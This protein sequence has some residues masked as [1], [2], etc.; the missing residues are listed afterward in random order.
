MEEPST[1][2]LSADQRAL[3]AAAD[4]AAA[5]YGVC[6]PDRVIRGESTGTESL[7][8]AHP[9]WLSFTVRAGSDR[10]V[11]WLRRALVQIFGL[12]A[13]AWNPK[14]RGWRGYVSSVGLGALGLLAFGGER[15][16]NT[17]HVQLYG[18]GCG[19]VRDWSAVRV[20]GE[21]CDAI[22]TRVDLAHDDYD[23]KVINIEQA[24]TWFQ[25]GQ[26]NTG[27]REPSHSITGDWLTD[28][29]P[30]GR[31]FYVG[32]R[33]NG[34]LCRVYEKGKQLGKPDSP[35]C[36]VEIEWRN[37][38]RKIPWSILTESDSYLSGAYPCLKFLARAH[39]RLRTQTSVAE[40]TYDNLVKCARTAYGSLI[41]VAMYRHRGD[42][43]GVIA[44][45]LR[46]GSPRR[47]AELTP[48][49]GQP[50]STLNQS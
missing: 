8:V 39:S 11:E 20:W 28:G 33:Q 13:S 10:T 46:E 18:Q 21:S 7:R 16:K 12:P 17:M 41:N 29:S 31:T 48:Y 47:L 50:R 35:W 40:I 23:G 9:D 42:A 25:E 37:K 24:V 32:K 43:E 30:K 45:F 34:K 5:D 19:C 6:S 36:R 44:E 38:D 22:I 26:F 49:L 2:I 15:Q 4:Y 27:G 14:K 3:N 1:K